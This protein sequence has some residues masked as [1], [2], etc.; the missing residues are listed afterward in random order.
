MP[1][2]TN[3]SVYFAENSNPNFEEQRTVDALVQYSKCTDI[4]DRK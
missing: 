1:H 4:L 3:E 2:F